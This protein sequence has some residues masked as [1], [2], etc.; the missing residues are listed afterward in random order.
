LDV[1][2]ARRKGEGFGGGRGAGAAV[3]KESGLHQLYLLANSLFCCDG[4]G[5]PKSSSVNIIL[6]VYVVH[7]LM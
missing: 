1:F 3:G 5:G 2:K 6:S 4:N 7:C